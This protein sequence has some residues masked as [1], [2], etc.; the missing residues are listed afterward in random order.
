M[1]DRK[2]LDAERMEVRDRYGWLVQAIGPRPIAL[3]TSV[4]E[5]GAVNLAPFSFFN[6]FGANPAVVA[7]SPT[8]RGVD[9]TAKDTLRNVVATR[10]FT[11]SVVTWPMVEQTNLASAEYPAEVDEFDMAGFTKL[12]SVKVRP[13][14]VGES[15]LVMEGRL[16]QHVELGGKSASAN[17]LIGEIVLFRI[18]QSVLDEKGKVDPSKLDQ[19]GRLGGNWYTRA[20]PGLFELPKP[21]GLPLGFDA[22]PPSVRASEVLT[23]AE[24]ARL[25]SV[26]VRPD[27]LPWREALVARYGTL[28]VR[29]LHEQIRVLL[30]EGRLEEAW[31]LAELGD[32]LLNG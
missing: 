15:P 14:G 25:A 28:S 21:T 22:L 18:A 5:K 2:N 27:T 24:L 11:I 23:G 4:D 10:E 17:L 16:L 7:F 8:N 12:P 32:R 3:V 13:P 19:V 20:R 6:G 31:S 9:G 29:Q 30:G 26:T 1:V